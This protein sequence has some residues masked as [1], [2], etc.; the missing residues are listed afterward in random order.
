[1]PGDYGNV[2]TYF[3]IPI[4]GPLIGAGVGAFLY[5]AVIRDVLIARGPAAPEPGRIVEDDAG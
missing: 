5:D 3:W 4:I 2:S 1:M